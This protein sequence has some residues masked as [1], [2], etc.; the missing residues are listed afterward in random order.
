MLFQQVSRRLGRPCWRAHARYL[1]LRRA[2]RYGG[3]VHASGRLVPRSSLAPRPASTSAMKISELSVLLPCH[4]L[5]DFPVYHEGAEAD[6]L[7]A[8]WCSFVAPGAVGGGRRVARLAPCGR[9]PRVAPGASDH[10]AAVLRGSPACRLRQPGRSR[11]R[12]AGAPGQSRR[13]GAGGTVRDRRDRHGSRPRVGCRFS[14][15]GILPPAN[16]VAHA[17]NALLGQHRRDAL[18]PRGHRR[19]R[20]PRCVRKWSRLAN[21]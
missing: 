9:A 13:R 7:L 1:D 16:G 21:I 12:R 8:A 18:R 15:A 4:S 5:E 17:A 19:Q 10:G 14:G 2:G 20:R 11:G 6:E 3:T